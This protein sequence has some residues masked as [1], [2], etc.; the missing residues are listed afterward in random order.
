MVKEYGHFEDVGFGKVGVIYEAMKFRSSRLQKL[1]KH[2]SL[3]LGHWRE[4]FWTIMGGPRLVIK[5]IATL[6]IDGNYS[7]RIKSIGDIFGSG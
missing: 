3:A 5:Q 2:K 6:L 1:C 7:T 4:K